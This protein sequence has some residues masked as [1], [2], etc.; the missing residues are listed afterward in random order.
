MNGQADA[1]DYE[2][3]RD[4]FREVL[5]EVHDIM[6]ERYDTKDVAI[7][8]LG[9]GR[10]SAV[11]TG[12]DRRGE[13]RGQGALLRQDPG[14]LGADD[15]QDH[16]AL[17]EHLPAHHLQGTPMFDLNASAEIMAK[18]QYQMLLRNL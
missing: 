1:I 3:H 7:F 14:Q 6:A 13:G 17:Q 12:Q 16:P 5:Q 2:A 8:P 9:S 10:L 11:H 15:H 18:H 4:F